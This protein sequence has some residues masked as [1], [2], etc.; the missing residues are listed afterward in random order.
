MDA[1]DAV[2]LALPEL[3]VEKRLTGS[4]HVDVENNLADVEE[5]IENGDADESIGEAVVLSPSTSMNV[6]SRA[7]SGDVSGINTSA[8]DEP[9]AVAF[10]DSSNETA[11]EDDEYMFGYRK[12]CIFIYGSPSI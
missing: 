1:V 5:L 4:T 9:G 12:V 3:V 11:V 6:L 7:V 2:P 10:I 8:S